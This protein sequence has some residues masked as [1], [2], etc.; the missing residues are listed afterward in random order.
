MRVLP[1]E[2]ANAQRNKQHSVK[3]G[4]AGCLNVRLSRTIF[5]DFNE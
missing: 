1:Y 2:L 4:H 5:G 3:K